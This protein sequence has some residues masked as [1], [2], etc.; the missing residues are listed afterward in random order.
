MGSASI[1]TCVLIELFP[2]ALP[3]VGT[4]DDL[5]GQAVHAYVCM[6]EESDYSKAPEKEAELKKA[7]G[8]QVRKVIGPFAAPK[9]IVSGF[10]LRVESVGD[11]G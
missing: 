9:K 5:T 10:V 2:F 8:I 4:A 11:D 3:V 1:S 7:L 6:K